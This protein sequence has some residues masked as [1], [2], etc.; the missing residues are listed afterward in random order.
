MV[1]IEFVARRRIARFQ[2]AAYICGMHTHTHMHTHT[3]RTH[4]RTHTRT[5]THTQL[6]VAAANGYT[7]VLD[8][9]F[10]HEGL[11]LDIQDN[12]GWTPFHAAVCWDQKE[13]M[14]MLA[15]KGAN[16]DVKDLHGDTAYGECKS[17]CWTVAAYGRY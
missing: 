9:L 11:N 10:S 14:K 6:H 15:Q 7:E 5:H 1:T 17:L 3:T 16:M 8:F 4:A 13:A 12:E 2:L